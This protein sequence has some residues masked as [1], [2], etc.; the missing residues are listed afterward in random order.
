[1]SDMAVVSQSQS[2]HRHQISLQ[3]APVQTE[4]KGD[5]KLS[6]HIEGQIGRHCHVLQRV[7]RDS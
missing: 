6:A 2:D 5:R 7:K 1:M 3:V 4:H